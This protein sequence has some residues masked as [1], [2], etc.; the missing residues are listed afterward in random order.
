MRLFEKVYEIDFEGR[1]LFLFLLSFYYILKDTEDAKEQT[2]SDDQ[3][4]S[5]D[6]DDQSDAVEQT[7][8]DDTS[9]QPSTVDIATPTVPAQ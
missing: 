3:I 6:T 8:T 2:E 1:P 9:D 7:K 4:D 5:G